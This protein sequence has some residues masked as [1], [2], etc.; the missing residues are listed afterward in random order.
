[1]T[2]PTLSNV[3][4]PEI[5][6]EIAIRYGETVDASIRASGEEVEFFATLKARL[7]REA[8]GARRGI[9]L[10][11][12]GCGTGMSTSALADALP[13]ATAIVGSDPSSES[14]VV[15]T[16]ER[17]DHRVSFVEQPS[18]GELPFE[19]ASFDVAFTA[20]VFHHIERHDHDAWMREL[21]RVLRPDGS[22]FIFEHNPCNP[23]TRRA[24]RLCPFDEG[25]ILLR[26][27]YTLRLM[28]EAGFAV[29]APHFYFFFPRTLAFLRGTEATLR[30]VPLGAQYFVRGD[31][32]TRV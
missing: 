24:V 4:G 6:D 32:S 7:V 21:H 13:S 14:I 1:M 28:S 23:L 17:S 15:A 16:A 18:V 9:R 3:T 19:S 29:S 31:R 26:P 5:F 2:S 10:L 27:S 12:F 11:D 30:R 20:C 8:I 25:V 22:L